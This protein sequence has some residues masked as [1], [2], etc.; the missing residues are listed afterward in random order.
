MHFLHY[1]MSIII[2]AECGL[3]RNGP[4]RLIDLRT[5][6]AVCGTVRKCG[7]AAVD[8]ALLEEVCHCR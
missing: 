5:W 3:N 6:K 2:E 7:F 4:P 8:E 1:D